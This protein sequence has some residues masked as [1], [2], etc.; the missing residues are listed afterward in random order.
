MGVVTVP[1]P[2]KLGSSVTLSAVAVSYWTRAKSSFVP[3]NVCPAATISPSDWIAT[4]L[5]TSL[6]E[7]IAVVTAPV[8]PQASSRLPSVL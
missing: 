7:P 2:L 4:A 8:P 5:A 6:V 3:S 1:V